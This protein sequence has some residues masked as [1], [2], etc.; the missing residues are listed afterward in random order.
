LAR[1]CA[2]RSAFRGRTVGLSCPGGNI[3]TRLL[4]TVLLRDLA[5]SGRMARL[6]IQ[7]QD[8]PGALLKVVTLFNMHGVNVLEVYHQRV[9]TTL[10]AKDAFIDVECEAKDAEQLQALVRELEAAGF[11]VHP[12]EIH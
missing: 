6:R 4:A 7:L 2:I 5:R 9:F 12:V 8:R 3:D 11:N 10:P 1:C